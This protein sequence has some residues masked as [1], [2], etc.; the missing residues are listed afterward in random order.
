M[1]LRDINL[2][3]PGI[4]IFI[5]SG[6]AALTVALLTVG[7]QAVKAATANPADCLRYE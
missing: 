7:Y 3:D 4:L 1:T 5:I 6:L 2:I